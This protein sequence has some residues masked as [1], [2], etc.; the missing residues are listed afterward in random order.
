MTIRDL[1]RRADGLAGEAERLRGARNAHAVRSVAILGQRIASPA[2]LVL[3]F[4]AG[5]LIGRPS[6]RA[7]ERPTRSAGDSRGKVGWLLES[8]V[9]AAA[10]RLASAFV[11]GAAVGSDEQAHGPG[12]SVK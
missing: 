5:I 8:P 10:L 6:S 1:R 2:G 9:G 11:T 4:G 3:C 7:P 12:P